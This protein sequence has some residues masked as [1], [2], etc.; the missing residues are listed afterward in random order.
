MLCG[1]AGY[2]VTIM[3]LGIMMP[4]EMTPASYN[5]FNFTHE[6]KT[7]VSEKSSNTDVDW[8]TKNNLFIRRCN[9]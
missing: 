9:N 5:A 1:L 8:F 2:P 6:S 3:L 7:H 4:G